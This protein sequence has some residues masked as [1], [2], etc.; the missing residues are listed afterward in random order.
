MMTEE[1]I[2]KG[3][4]ALRKIT[5]RED[6]AR[7]SLQ[8]I[9]SPTKGLVLATSTQPI[10]FVGQSLNFILSATFV[11]AALLVIF[12]GGAAGIL[13]GYFLPP[14]QA[15]NNP[16]LL[17]EATAINK[18]IDLQLKEIEYLSEDRPLVALQANQALTSQ[19]NPA[20]KTTDHEIDQLL[21]QVINQQ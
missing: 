12:L 21:N 9:L 18:D 7:E 5:P 14:L 1:K 13:K 15:V 3:L 17:S 10:N 19:N 11:A 8:A 16:A 4:E 20:D 2:I 6:Y